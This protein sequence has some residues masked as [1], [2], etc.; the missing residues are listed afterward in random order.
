MEVSVRDTGVG[1]ASQD[2]EKIFARFQRLEVPLPE[3]AP[4]T[5]LGLAIVKEIID[6]HQGKVWTESEPG[7]GSTFYFTLDFERQVKGEEDKLIPPEAL[8]GMRVLVVDDSETSCEI[9]KE[10][11]RSLTFK[12]TS[13][14][15]AE[16]ALEELENVSDEN[17]FQLVLI[18]FKVPGITTLRKIKGRPK[19]S[20]FGT[21]SVRELTL[22][23]VDN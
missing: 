1:I 10:M 2:L 23:F 15:T 5:G 7:K 13:V 11:L 8:Q 18:D 16:K 9:L 3:R 22:I 20:R 14:N 6:L 12:A 21:R 17:H 4:G 19:C